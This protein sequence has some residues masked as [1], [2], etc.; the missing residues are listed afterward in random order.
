MMGMLSQKDIDFLKNL[1]ARELRDPVTFHLFTQ[2]ESPL[3]VPALECR[4]CKETRMLLEEVTALSDRLRL[5]THDFVQ[6][7]ELAGEY[8]ISRIP[9]LELRGH[10]R[11]RVRFFGI[12]TGFEFSILVEDIIEISRGATKLAATTREALAALTRPIHIQ[13][14]A[15][16][17]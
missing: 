14:F 12:P 8:E 6:E 9:A 7:A 5:E 11:G 3:P 17:T 1:F 10:T 15:T 4:F 16:P 2:G 13:V